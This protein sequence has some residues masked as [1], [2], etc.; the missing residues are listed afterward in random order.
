MTTRILRVKKRSP[1]DYFRSGSNVEHTLNYNRTNKLKSSLLCCRRETNKKLCPQT[2][3]PLDVLMQF[4]GKFGYKTI[5]YIKTKSMKHADTIVSK[6]GFS[7]SI[8]V[9]SF[10]GINFSPLTSA[11]ILSKT[12]ADLGKCFRW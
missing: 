7:D 2:Y 10:K 6:L 5:G 9:H 4:F 3:F 1:T 12:R 8:G 11:T